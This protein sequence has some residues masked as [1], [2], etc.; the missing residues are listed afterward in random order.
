MM[1]T[2]AQVARLDAIFNRDL[3][4]RQKI[5]RR[6]LQL[7]DEVRRAFLE[8]DDMMLQRASAELAPLQRQRNTRRWLM[9]VKMYRTLTPV[10]RTK[11]SAL[12]SAEMP[13]R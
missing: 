10:Q 6:I 13:R 1:L 11:L 2:V 3:P 4:S 8:E 5:N 9:L 12:R 7:D